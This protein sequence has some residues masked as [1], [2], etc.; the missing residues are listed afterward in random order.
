M[1]VQHKVNW[2]RWRSLF[3][4]LTL[5]IYL[6]LYYRYLTGRPTG[7]WLYW[8]AW[9]GIVLILM[10][11]I[12]GRWG[13]GWFCMYSAA[14]EF[15]TNHLKWKRIQL[16][17]WMHSWYWVYGFFMFFGSFEIFWDLDFYIWYIHLFDIVAVGIGLFIIPRHWCR[18]ICPLGTGSMVYGR[19]RTYGIKADPEKCIHCK[20]VVYGLRCVPCTSTERKRWW[21]GD[22]E[23]P[24]PIASS[25]CTAYRNVL[26]MFPHSEG[27][28][29][30]RIKRKKDFLTNTPSMHGMLRTPVILL[31]SP[32]IHRFL[33]RREVE[34]PIK[35]R[36][37]LYKTFQRRRR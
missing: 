16:P 18:Y 5:L 13:C 6:Y 12:F 31:R 10:P 15:V 4:F 24:L 1:I 2:Q 23:A 32:T 9:F 34:N 14:I 7:L 33:L 37:C 22:V 3:L 20:M 21:K 11:A 28:A 25:V 27:F 36:L 30:L 8:W 35:V 26:D 29:G 19:I 17:K